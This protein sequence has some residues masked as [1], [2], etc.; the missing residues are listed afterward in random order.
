MRVITT[1]GARYS[2][3]V[4]HTTLLLLLYVYVIFF[5]YVYGLLVMYVYVLFNM[6]KDGVPLR[7]LE[8]DLG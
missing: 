5:M 7:R 1:V 2:Q 3:G 8:A 6:F 4:I